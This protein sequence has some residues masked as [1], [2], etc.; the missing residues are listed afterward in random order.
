M[1]RQFLVNNSV[2]RHRLLAGKTQQELAAA[3]GVTRQ[4]IISIEKGNYTP[5]IG[6]ALSLA[7]ELEVAVDILFQLQGASGDE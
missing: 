5:S 2:K 3:V 7:A 6:L 4:T 1:S